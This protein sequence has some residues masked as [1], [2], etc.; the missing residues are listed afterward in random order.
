MLG[1]MRF[2][3]DG[4]VRELSGFDPTLTVLQWLRGAERRC[5]TKEGCA[6]GDCGACT[7]VLG[8]LSGGGVRLR[9]VNACILFLPALDGKALFT[10][11][12]L[13]GA[14]G[15]LHAVQEAMVE[16]H[17]SQC[18]FCTPGFVMSLF[19]LYESEGRPSRGRLDDVLAGNLCRC[20]G[21]RPIVEAAQ[22]AYDLGG[23]PAGPAARQRLAA[24]L[25]GI[26]RPDMLALEHQGRRFFAPRTLEELAEL[27]LREPGADLLAGGTDVGLWVTKGHRTLETVVYLGEVEELRRL[28]AGHDHLDIGAAVTYADAHA[29]LAA[30]HPD[31]GELV[32]RIGSVQIRNLGT[33]GGNLANAS[34]V[35]DMPPALLALEARLVMRRGPERRELPLEAFFQGYRKTALLP[36]EF[37]E[38][39]V[40]PR[41]APARLFRAYKVSKRF[42]QDIAAV[43]GA[44]S[45]ELENGRVKDPRVAYGGMAAVPKRARACEAAL[46]GR[47]WTEATVLAAL[48]AL[49]E[50]LAPISDMRASAAY[51]RL[52]ARNLLVKFQLETGGRRA[53]TR[54]VGAPEGRA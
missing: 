44:F 32:R 7:V 40:V 39:I 2:I 1:T 54:V 47:P 22:R 30:L 36:G 53:P 10:V 45:L 18:G 37:L 5:G 8:E 3:L 9:A 42:D 34:P 11:E 52:V 16:C 41:L 48:P 6:E 28:E 21:Y 43:C 35:G 46:A 15:E 20:T 17:G 25:L 29:A 23:G 14:G 31:L 27:V 26:R 19:A 4:R 38:A 33:V 13:R 50:D 49:D 24:D 12:S 51:R